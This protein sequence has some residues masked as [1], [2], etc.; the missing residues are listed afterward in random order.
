MA[1]QQFTERRGVA[2]EKVR[3]F[4]N[5]G[6]ALIN[7]AAREVYSHI[8]EDALSRSRAQVIE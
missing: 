1:Q 7:G 4:A 6:N 5:V 3:D 2:V 8:R